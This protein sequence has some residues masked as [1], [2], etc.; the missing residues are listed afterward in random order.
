LVDYNIKFDRNCCY[1]LGFYW[2]K[3]SR[4]HVKRMREPKS[5]DECVYFTKRK[6]S[7]S[8]AK[9]WVFKGQCPECKIG[10][11]GKPRDS[12]TGRAKIRSNDYVCPECNYTA[13]KSKYEETLTASIQYE[14]KC[15]NKSG[16]EVPF[17]RKKVMRFDE[18]DQKK[19]SVDALVFNCSKCDQRFL[20]TKKMK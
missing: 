7:E 17:K 12:K 5:M 13:E 15:G 20:I 8:F 14:C 9:V 18:E 11:M 6:D 1:L 10:L 19:R 2:G 4:G 16:I 3:D